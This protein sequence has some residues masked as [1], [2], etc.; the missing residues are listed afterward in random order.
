MVP[1]ETLDCVLTACYYF[2]RGWVGT[3]PVRPS[4]GLLGALNEV[5]C[6]GGWFNPVATSA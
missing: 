1:I 3:V 4:T 6:C 5:S 2:S